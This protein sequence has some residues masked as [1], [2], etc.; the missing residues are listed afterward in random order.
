MTKIVIIDLP[1]ANSAVEM[2][3]TLNQLGHTVR[4]AN[5]KE[6]TLKNTE[7]IILPGGYSF[8]DYLRP[9]ALAKDVPVMGAVKKFARD[10]GP[11][12]GIGNGFQIL[13]EA[14]ILP[15]ILFQNPTLTFFRNDIYVKVLSNNT[16]IT[17]NIEPETV[18]KLPLACYYGSYYTDKRTINDM[19]EFQKITLKYCDEFGE[20]HY[21]DS[22]PTESLNAVAGIVSRHGNV[23]GLMPRIDRAVSELFGNTN[24]LKFFESL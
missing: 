2:S 1:G 12:L 18:L 10:E 11:V 14:K 5:Y 13:C 21:N 17:K 22:N 20:I 15:G 23:V 24:G 7:L 6:E 4:I 3:A 8:G 19:E 16:F 9:G